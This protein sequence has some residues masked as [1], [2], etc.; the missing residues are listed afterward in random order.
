MRDLLSGCVYVRT[1]EHYLDPLIVSENKGSSRDFFPET[2]AETCVGV[3]RV[4][5]SYY[6]GL[7]AGTYIHGSHP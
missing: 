3:Y 7:V 2:P 6:P 1:Y 4:R 5:Y